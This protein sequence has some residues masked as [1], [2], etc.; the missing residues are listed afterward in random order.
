MRNRRIILLL[1]VLL[2]VLWPKPSHANIISYLRFEE[3]S[4]TWAMDQTGLMNGE[5]LEDWGPLEGWTADVPCSAIPLTG[6]QNLYSI[7][8]GGG[9]EFID[10]SNGNDVNLGTNFTVE[11][12]LK[13]EQPVIASVAFAF[14]PVSGLGLTVAE[15]EGRNYFWLGFQSESRLIPTPELEIGTWQHLALVKE[16]G[17]Y[18]LYL[19]GQLFVTDTLP[20]STDGPYWFPGTGMTG[21]RT[22]GGESGT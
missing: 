5:L 14:A 16:P 17:R 6:Q 18:S 20:S 4:G 10:L 3:G 13:P 8:F 7:R 1:S 12:Y 2:S 15:G 21:D 11:F 9:S 22:I 19:N